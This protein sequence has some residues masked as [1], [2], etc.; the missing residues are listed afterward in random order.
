MGL[1]MSEATFRAATF[2]FCTT[3][4]VVSSLFQALLALNVRDQI[5]GSLSQHKVQPSIAQQ[6]RIT[7][8]GYLE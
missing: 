5:I 8:P 2:N 3:P 6:H 4:A 7:L 1:Y